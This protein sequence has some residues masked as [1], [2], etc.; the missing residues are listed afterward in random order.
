MLFNIFINDLFFLKLN[1]EI[2]NFADDN[3]LYSYGRDLNEMVTNLEIDLSIL[4][5]WFA[6]NGMVAKPKKFQ[7]MF[8]GLTRHRR[9]R[10]NIEGNKVSAADCVKL[11]GVE[12]D[13]KV[14]FDKHVKTLCS[15]ANMKINAFSR[16]DTYISREQA[17]LICRAVLLSD[18]NYCPL[19]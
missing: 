7:L 14:K 1:S 5:K 4:F 9:L 3:T 6:E 16:L 18:F 19:I 2:C 11:L 10:L 12:I 15:K 13:N 8:L 17:S